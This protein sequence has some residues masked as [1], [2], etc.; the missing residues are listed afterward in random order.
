LS[1][2]VLTREAGSLRVSGQGTIGLDGHIGALDLDQLTLFG[3]VDGARGREGWR[4]QLG[5]GNCLGLASEAIGLQSIVL[6]TVRTR[7]CPPD[8]RL[9]RQGP[10][11]PEGMLMVD[12][13]N[14]DLISGRNRGRLNL[15]SPTVRWTGGNGINAALTS[16]AV[17]LDLSIGSR[18]V[19]VSAN[20][21]ELGISLG[22][23]GGTQ[24]TSGLQS[25]DFGGSL[26]PAQV[27][28]DSAQIRFAGGEARGSLSQVRIADTRS[29]PLYQPVLA[30][31]EAE[32][33][34]SR[35]HLSGPVRL[36]RS[37]RHIAD[38]ELNL[39]FPELNGGLNLTS[40]DLTFRPGGLQL[41]DLS[42]RLRGYFTNTR[43]R[44][45]AQ[46]EIAITGGGV[47]SRGNVTVG[48]FG[49]QTVALGRVTD[50]NGAVVFEDL[51]KLTSPP[52][53]TVTIGAINPGLPLT[54]G[55][56]K[57]QLTG[58][59]SARLESALW[60]FAGG[61]LAVQ[62][63]SWE[64]GAPSRRLTVRADRIRLAELTEVLQ[65]PGFSAEGTVSGRFPIEFSA[66]DAYIRDARLAAD[67]AGGTLRYTGDVGAR[68]GQTNENVALAF[69][70]LR[71]FRF[72]VLE[73]GADG[74]LADDIVLSA[75]LQGH[76]PDVLNGQGFNFNVSVDSKLGQ[77]LSSTRQLTG[78]DWLAEI[79]AQ[80]AE[81]ESDE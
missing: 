24:I 67:A 81:A 9:I 72:T 37:G 58:G 7:L 46:A 18:D 6:D 57:F 25:V 45:D 20:L 19:T 26:I 80:Q 71:D 50:V 70:A 53:Q 27:S 62:P 43:G 69:R 1:R 30:D 60:P 47:T 16:E 36:E 31:L 12:P 2:L 5:E 74:N 61:V 68:A 77:L 39:A 10:E 29:D 78:T 38:A 4:A 13:L 8:G 44:L 63:T 14:L 34:A 66:G 76:N 42:E 22:R 55:E 3:A 73:I 65:M 64:I 21:A 51:F 75:R 79:R 40:H 32:L 17:Q 15:P 54:D 52:A 56:V 28:A 48:G 33:A 35:L 23:A 49:F 11:G 59:G 41:S